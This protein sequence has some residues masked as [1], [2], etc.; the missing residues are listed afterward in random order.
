[1]LALEVFEMAV[2]SVRYTP[3]FKRQMVDLVR[4]G[5][6]PA[7]LSKE[8]GPTAWS[9]S[10]WVKQAQR[11]IGKGDGGLTTAEREELSRLRREVRKLKEEREILSK[12]AAWFAT[13]SGTSKRS[14]GS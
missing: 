1:M 14:S 13:E 6:S 11:D 7:S 2:K 5:R 8:F 9:I 12:A 10:L 4:S 3:E